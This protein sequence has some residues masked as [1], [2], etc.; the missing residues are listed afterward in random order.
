MSKNRKIIGLTIMIA[1]ILLIIFTLYA[2]SSENT[3]TV[4]IGY[5]PTDHDAALFVANATGMFKDEGIDVEFYE[6]NNGGDMMSAMAS[7]ELDAGYVGITPVIYSIS[8]D[9]PVKI[10]S[11]AQNEGSG[12]LSHSPSVKSITD[13]KGKT[14]ATPGE[15]SIQSVLLK[16]D[17]KKNGLSTSDIESP[18]MKVSSMN[19]ALKTDGIDAMLTYE[20]YVT[21]SKDINNQTLVENSADILPDHPCCVVIMN[22]KF[23]SGE[24]DK[25]SKILDIHKRATEKIKEN[26]QG[27]I[28]Y[29]PPHIVPDSEIEKESLAHIKWVS[30]LNDTY[31][32]NVNEFLNIEKDLGIINGDIP[33]EKLFSEI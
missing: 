33:Q 21:I 28:Q 5:L 26:P 13:L 4:K 24:S 1:V 23:L 8:K 25:S 6:Y 2:M 12:L 18:T 30:D 32:K 27:A 29:L 9:V 15:A 11:G 20:P 31:K 17:L 19:D 14:V 10:V 22:Q 16:Y 3:E 7:G